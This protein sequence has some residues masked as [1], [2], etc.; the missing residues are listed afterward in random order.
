MGF[1]QTVDAQGKPVHRPGK[2][3][4]HQIGLVRGQFGNVPEAKWLKFIADTGFDGWEEAS[5]ELD[6]RRCDTDAGA[7]AYAKERVDAG[8]EARAGNL[9]RRHPPARAGAGRRAE[10]QDAQLLLRQG[11]RRR[12]R[13][14]RGGQAGNSPP[15]TDPYFVPDEVGKLVHEEAATRPAG[16]RAA[17]PGTCRKLQNRK[18]ALPGFVGSPAHCWS[19]WFLFP[20]L[21][22]S[23]EGY[24]I[25]DVRQVSLEL[26]V[27]RFGPVWDVCKQ[28]R[29]DVRPG[30]PPAR[31]GDGRP[32]D[33]P[34]TTSTHMGKAGFE[35]RGRVQPRRLAHGVA[36]RVGDPV[37]PRVRR[38]TS[39]APT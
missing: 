17:T 13:T 29:R 24:D 10:R 30:V 3:S 37:H 20:P 4:H 23:M 21:P 8:Q 28:V 5:W 33:A 34:P 18:V 31:A 2:G 9:H 11:R 22:A 35:R 27:E 19:H 36:E 26:L 15:R 6:L 14:R 25:P 1:A 7:A 39:T 38:S 12:P 32:R 16:V